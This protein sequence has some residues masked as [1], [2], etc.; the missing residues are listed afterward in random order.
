DCGVDLLLAGHNHR[1]SAHSAR[2]LVTRAGSSLVVQAGT[3]TSTRLRDEEQ[4]F[5]QI[6]IDGEAVTLTVQAWAGDGFESGD[7]QLYVRGGDHWRIA[8]AG[9]KVE[10]ATH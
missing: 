7:A 8:G 5:N 4:S 2:D 10:A 6:D 3:A 1:A 9:Q